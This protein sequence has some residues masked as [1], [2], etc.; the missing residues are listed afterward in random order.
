MKNVQ[1]PESLLFDLFCYFLR[2]ETDEFITNDIVTALE[3][4]LEAMARHELY[5]QSKTADTPA[6]REAARQAYLDRVGM[7][8][9]YRWPAGWKPEEP[10]VKG[11]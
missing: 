2:G 5:T 11:V 1:I 9:G 3:N 6:A 8:K 7:Q 4:K 10:P